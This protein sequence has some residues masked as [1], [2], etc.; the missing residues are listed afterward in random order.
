MLTKKQVC[1][2]K[3]QYA[4][5]KVV[6]LYAKKQQIQRDQTSKQLQCII[7]RISANFRHKKVHKKVHQG[8]QAEAR[9]SKGFA[10]RPIITENSNF[11]I[12]ICI[13]LKILAFLKS[14]SHV[15]VP[16]GSIQSIFK[17]QQGIF[18]QK[19][20]IFPSFRL[21]ST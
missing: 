9:P 8:M 1:M 3:S 16:S 18:S 17:Q 20:A 21:Q 7:F 5:L 19:S 10:F 2:I 12:K 11:Q 15:K 4:L 14:V 13:E 6:Y